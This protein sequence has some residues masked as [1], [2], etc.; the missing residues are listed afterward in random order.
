MDETARSSTSSPMTRSRP[1]S[2]ACGR[3]TPGGS[4]WWRRVAP[5]RRRASVALRL[6]A[7]AAADEG[8]RSRWWP[9]RRR[10]PS[11][12]RRASATSPRWPRTHEGRPGAPAAAD[13]ADARTAASMSCAAR[14]PRTR[15]VP[16]AVAVAGRP[17]TREAETEPLGPCTARRSSRPR[18]GA[19]AAAHIPRHGRSLRRAG[20]G[21]GAGVAGARSSF[22][23]R[24]CGSCRAT[25]R[26]G[27]IT[28]D[29]GSPAPSTAPKRD[30]SDRV[31]HGHRELRHQR[32]GRRAGDVLQLEH[33]NVEVAAGSLVASGEADGDRLHHASS[34]SWCR[35]ARL[36]R[37]SGIKAGEAS[38]DVAAV[39]PD[40]AGNVAAGAID[41]IHDDSL[42]GSCAASRDNPKRLVVNPEPT[43][44]GATRVRTGDRSRGRR[45]GGGRS[46]RGAPDRG[47][48]ALP[49]RSRSAR[50][51]R[52]SSAVPN[53]DQRA[54][55][56]GRR[57]RREAA[58]ELTGT[59]AYDRPSR[60]SPTSRPRRGPGLG[61]HAAPAS[62][63]DPGQPSTAVDIASTTATATALE[64]EAIT[65]GTPRRGHRR[66][67]RAP[68]RIAGLASPRRRGGPGR[69]RRGDR[70]ALAG[71]GRPPCPA[72]T[73]A[74]HRTVP[75]ERSSAS[76]ERSSGSTT[77]AGGSAWP[78]A[79]ARRG[80]PSLG[81][82]LRRGAAPADIDAVGRRWRDE[83][84]EPRGRRACRVN[85]DGSEGTQAAAAR[86][87]GE[88]W[89][90]SG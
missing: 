29:F 21:A 17:S 83:G 28:Y 84:A 67:C 78:S 74:S 61:R 2:V 65:S 33:F 68:R 6:L 18:A 36:T 81:P 59:L 7:R 31:R 10:A 5:E 66:R 46:H 54:R 90:A 80:W 22:P 8:A 72:R 45:C 77:A 4:C 88:R 64:V 30:R 43:G 63:A 56:P 25:S 75:V 44:G 19:A 85:M 1:S 57:T 70:R 62:G 86:A 15:A 53:R 24:R 9:T 41:T 89:R 23:P 52:R 55:R 79:T 60:I 69:P 71:L 50:S 16:G 87:F 51:R 20:R 26:V 11:P 38:V 42:E 32:S 12:P 37:S 82:A 39:A 27:P 47:R 49:A 35:P 58:F 14:R 3:P 13:P 76:P 40:P 73:G 34:R 48:R